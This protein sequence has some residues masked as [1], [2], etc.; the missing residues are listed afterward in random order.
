[1]SALTN[2]SR[3]PSRNRAG[4]R[5][6]RGRGGDHTAGRRRLAH[7]GV[8]RRQCV[9]LRGPLGLRARPGREP[10]LVRRDRPRRSARPGSQGLWTRWPVGP[11]P[12][13]SSRTSGARRRARHSRGSVGAPF[14]RRR[15]RIRHRGRRQRGRRRDESVHHDVADLRRPGLH[16]AAVARVVPAWISLPRQADRDPGQ[17]R[18]RPVLCYR[19]GVDRLPAG[20]RTTGR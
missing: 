20:Q 11:M 1:M 5:E 19:R 14:T 6:Q 2:L 9:G 7:R 16:L 12:T 15:R 18:R 10:R 3:G 4:R 17:V 13:S 8:R